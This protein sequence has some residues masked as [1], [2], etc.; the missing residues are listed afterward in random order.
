[1]RGA[2]ARAGECD[3][4]TAVNCDSGASRR[5]GADANGLDM[6]ALNRAVQDNPEHDQHG[7]H[8]Q[9]EM[10]HAPEPAYGDVGEFAGVGELQRNS[11]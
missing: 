2:G 11:A 6:L 9:H 5:L 1:M 10:R 4:A 3:N 8:D 7:R